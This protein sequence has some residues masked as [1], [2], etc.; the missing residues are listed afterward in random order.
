MQELSDSELIA[1]HRGGDES[2]FEEVI[3]R[4]LKPV[5]GFVCRYLGDRD[6]AEDIV[7]EAFLRAWRH[8]DRFDADKNFR[9]W[10]FRIARNA[11]LDHIKKK[12]P[13]LFS[14]FEREDGGN[15]LEETLADPSEL[16][17][18]LLDRGDLAKT[19]ATAVAGLSPIY[20]TVMFLRYNDHLTFQEISEALG[21]PIDTVKSR[22]RRALISLKK[23]LTG[24]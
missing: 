15:V 21:E 24:T 8:L 14:E 20:R 9:T 3:R 4:H 19:A 2:A 23:T 13:A 5:Y 6:D 18:E 11:A 7:Q 12:R 1:R 17:S 10:L 22:H 16:P